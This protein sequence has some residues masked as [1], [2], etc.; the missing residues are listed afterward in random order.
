MRRS[1]ASSKP[2][3]YTP[4]GVMIGILMGADYCAEHECGIKHLERMLGIMPREQADK[5]KVFGADRS[6]IQPVDPE[7]L[8]F[9]ETKRTHEAILLFTGANWSEEERK[10]LTISKLALRYN[11]HLIKPYGDEEP[12]SLAAAWDDGSFGIHVKGKQEHEW[13]KEIYQAL[14]DGDMIVYLGQAPLPAFSNSSL[15]LMIRSRIPQEGLDIMCQAHKEVWELN[16]DAK[17][18]G[19]YEKLEKAGRRYYA[20]SPRRGLLETRIS[21]EEKDGS[22][23]KAVPP[24]KHDLMFWLN[25]TE[26]N[27]NHSGWYT[28]E[29]LEQWAEGKGPII[30]S[31]KGE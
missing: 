25:P 21:G 14:I 19:I 17:A 4:D 15:N 2:E 22:R 24:S 12:Q 13:L 27:K 10:N 3:F 5:E 23:V 31:P 29:E 8:L 30:A 26:Q 1:G 28:V 11:I 18:T 7:R 20:L 6:L 9:C 16:R